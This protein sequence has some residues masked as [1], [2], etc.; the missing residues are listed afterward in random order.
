MNH[1]N[2]P[3]PSESGNRQTP[4]KIYPQQSHGYISM[5]AKPIGNVAI[6]CPSRAKR[7][8][9]SRKQKARGAKHKTWCEA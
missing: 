1:I 2:R 5:F 4:K 7:R 3:L 9:Y 8:L 6:F